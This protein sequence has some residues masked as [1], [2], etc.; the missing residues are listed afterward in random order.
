[1]NNIDNNSNTSLVSGNQHQEKTVEKQPAT[2]PEFNKAVMGR[3]RA[4]LEKSNFTVNEEI[5][6]KYIN[7]T[8]VF[9]G[10]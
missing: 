2:E 3:I 1:M 8:R 5:G 7:V 9:F 6:K 4:M 10:R